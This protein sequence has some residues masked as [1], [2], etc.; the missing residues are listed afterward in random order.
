MF[1]LAKSPW[2]RR[3]KHDL[4]IR[5]LRRFEL[6]VQVYLMPPYIPE[7]LEGIENGQMRKSDN[8]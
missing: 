1:L 7:R 5:F 8:D 6:S 3:M 4:T 2:I